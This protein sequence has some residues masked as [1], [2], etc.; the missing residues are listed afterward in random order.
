MTIEEKI[1]DISFL[2]DNSEKGKT[3]IGLMKEDLMKIIKQQIKE[4]HRK[5]YL[6]CEKIYEVSIENIIKNNKYLK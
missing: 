6:A 3:E 4:S 1:D 5:G 2:I